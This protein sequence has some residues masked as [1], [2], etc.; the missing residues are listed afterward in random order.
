[1]KLKNI[2]EDIKV[3]SIKEAQNEIK[4]IIHELEDKET[5][6][7]DSIDRYKRMMQLNEHIQD[8]F[9][10][11]AKEINKNSTEKTTKK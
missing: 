7:Q 10:K 11:R 6:I 1:M 9:R 2:P 8:E 4:G 3:K 5:S